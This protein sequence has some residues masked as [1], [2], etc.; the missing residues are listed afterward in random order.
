[1][2]SSSAG[3]D[4]FETE[5]IRIVMADSRFGRQ[6]FWIAE[7]ENF[8]V[9]IREVQAVTVLMLGAGK[10]GEWSAVVHGDEKPTV[11]NARGMFIGNHPQSRRASDRSFGVADEC[12]EAGSLGIGL[13]VAAAHPG[14][15]GVTARVRHAA[16][17]RGI[18][19][20]PIGAG[21]T[22][23]G[24]QLALAEQGGVGG[25]AGE[26]QIARNPGI[27]VLRCRQ[28][29]RQPALVVGGIHLGGER[30]LFEIVEATSLLPAGF[31][32]I[33]RWQQ[34]CGEDGN[35]GNHHQHFDQGEPAAADDTNSVPSRR[36]RHGSPVCGL[37]V[38]G[39][40]S[41]S[42]VFALLFLSYFAGDGNC[43]FG[44]TP[45]G[46]RL[47]CRGGRRIIPP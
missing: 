31:C 19:G 46:L 11:I 26:L 1:M 32:L 29:L 16:G 47:R 38:S 24:I 4:L 14:I 9:T 27:A 3:G 42:H 36:L 6:G 35:Y 25:F 22:G 41:F 21:L 34:Q 43:A 33:Q 30:Q 37:R 10:A 20:T 12:P 40:P 15:H 23:V 2:V 39:H 18:G 7:L 8:R 28:I 45:S 5:P 44:R 17:V 13:H